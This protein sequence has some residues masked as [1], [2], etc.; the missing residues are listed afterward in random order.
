MR[1]NVPTK[2]FTLIELLVVIA[3]IGVLSSVV[4]ASLNTAR[5]KAADAAVKAQTE[6]LRNVM[7]FEYTDTGSYSAIKSGS[8]NGAGWVGIS[9]GTGCV[10]FT[11]TYATQASNI[12]NA[13]I[14]ANG[15]TCGGT[16]T[17][18]LATNPDAPDKFTILSYL[19]YESA[20]AG[21]ARWFC[22][23]SGGGNSIDAGGWT[24]AGC[25]NNP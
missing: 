7:A 15:S 1:T 5:L 14:K 19:P 11:G 6:Q 17:W 8:G 20:K 13:L 10:G 3:I 23:G 2:G 4:L 24:G 22:M 9:G 21:G 25:Y 18:F 12:C 16:C